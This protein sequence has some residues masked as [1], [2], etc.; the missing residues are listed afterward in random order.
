MKAV[1]LSSNRPE[2]AP[3]HLKPETKAWW[4]AVVAE[5]QLEEHHRKLLRLACESWDRAQD[6]REAIATHGQVFIDNKGNPHARPEIAIARDATIGFSRLL[7][8]LDLDLEAPASS[9]IR[10]PA[11]RSNSRRF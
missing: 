9:D 11:L 1:Q 3:E 5:F 8:E 7:R 10:P 4:S 6:A 2:P